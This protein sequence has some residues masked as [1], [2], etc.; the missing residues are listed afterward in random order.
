MKQNVLL[1]AATCSALLLPPTE[2]SNAQLGGIMNPPCI[3]TSF[4][5]RKPV[6]YTYLRDADVMWSRRIWRVIDL[7]EKINL[8]LYFP[9]MPTN[10]LYSLFDIIKK[11]VISGQLSAYGNPVMDDQFTI[12]LGKTEIEKTFFRAD[13]I[14]VDDLSGGIEKRVVITEVMPQDIKQYWIKED[15]FFDKQRSVLD[16]RIIG[17][18]P[19]KESKDENGDVRGYTPMFWI[20]FP[21]LRQFLAK[22]PVYNRGNNGPRLSFDDL[23][24]KRQFSSYIRKADNVYDRAIAEYKQGLDA[25]LESEAIKEDIFNFEHDLWHF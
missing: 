18:A 17:I 16:V 25:L 24:W 10:C 3:D 8:P 4:L 19:L 22:N 15:W 7:R 23:F 14:E 21:E 6:P 20:Y 11:N 9:L 1:L 12:Q 2:E 13:T 5:N